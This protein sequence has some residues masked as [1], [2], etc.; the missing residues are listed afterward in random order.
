MQAASFKHDG[1]WD[2]W[3]EA[4]LLR[5]LPIQRWLRRHGSALLQMQCSTAFISKV[6]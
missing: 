3:S 5:F 6:S 2:D 1:Y 4:R